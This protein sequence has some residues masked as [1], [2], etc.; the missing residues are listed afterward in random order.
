MALKR[1]K[2]SELKKPKI[3][4]K[5]LFLCMRE[6]QSVDTSSLDPLSLKDRTPMHFANIDW[7]NLL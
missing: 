4:L 7:E 3:V 2:T 5:S 6:Q 1:F